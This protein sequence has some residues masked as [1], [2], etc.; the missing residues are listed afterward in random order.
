LR[1]DVVVVGAGPAGLVA[2]RTVASSGYRVVVLE[3]ERRLGVKPCGEACSRATLIDS[4]VDPEGDF[5]VREIAGAR[6]YAPNGSSVS[7]QGDAGVGCIL[8]KALYLEHLA[9]K[10]S[11]A[12]ADIRVGCAVE[13]IK[14]NDSGPN[15]ADGDGVFRVGVRPGAGAGSSIEDGFEASIMIGADGFNSTVARSFSLEQRGER[16]LI[17]CVQYHMVNCDF[18]DEGVAEFYLGRNIAPLGYA[19]AFPKGGGRANVGVGVRGAPAKS[20]L[21]RFVEQHS[22]MFGKARVVGLEAAPVTVGGLLRRVVADGVV[23]VGEA[24]GQVVPLTGAGIHSG[25][26]GAQM[27]GLVVSDALAE[28]DVS[29]AML[30]RYQ[31]DYATRWGRRIEDS[32]K[33]MRALERLSDEDLNELASLLSQDDVLDLANG[34]DITRVAAK[35]MRHPLLGL[36]LARALMG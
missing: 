21:D 23:L 30:E 9:S 36:R 25:V 11:E 31:R 27:A 14:R 12:G 35:F 2:A 5:V 28:G 26:A 3:R 29:A 10:A 18:T 4:M 6:V 13:D 8:D 1:Y 19:W 16:E 20:Y 32:L 33:A 7:I 22:K 15:R 24:A 17:P 34:L